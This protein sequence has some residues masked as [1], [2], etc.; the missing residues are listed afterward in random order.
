MAKKLA[1]EKIPTRK[2]VARKPVAPVTKNAVRPAVR[3]RKVT[4]SNVI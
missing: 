4:K 1:A 2:P 3:K